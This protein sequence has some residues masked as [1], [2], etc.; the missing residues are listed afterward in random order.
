MKVFLPVATAQNLI[1][2]TRANVASVDLVI[3]NELTK[4]TTTTSAISTSYLDGYLT[5]P[6]SHDFG[7]GET[8]EMQVV[9]TDPIWR[10]KAFITA[11]TPELYKLNG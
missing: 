10:G 8:Y 3:R 9:D 7:E 4:E 2:R 11:Q 1:V 5:V 6:F